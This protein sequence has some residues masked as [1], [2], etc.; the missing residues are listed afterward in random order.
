VRRF[1]VAFKG[2]ANDE[3]RRTVLA[4]FMAGSNGESEAKESPDDTMK[5][6]VEVIKELVQALSKKL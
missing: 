5:Q 4:S 6:G 2:S 1:Y 3:Q